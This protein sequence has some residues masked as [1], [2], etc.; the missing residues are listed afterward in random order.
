MILEPRATILKGIKV[1]E[2][3]KDVDLPVNTVQTVLDDLVTKNLVI[4]IDDKRNLYYGQK[5]FT[6]LTRMILQILTE[7]HRANPLETGTE[8]PNSPRS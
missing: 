1:E 5:N 4:S 2:I 8:R 7:Y 6:D 3:A